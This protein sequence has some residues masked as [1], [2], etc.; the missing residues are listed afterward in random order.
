MSKKN[1]GCLERIERLKSKL[2]EVRPEMDLENA[3]I[4]TES[5]METEGLP[6]V[7]RKAKAFHKQCSEKT[8][9]I[10]E[11][12]LIVGCSGSKK[13]GGILCADTCWSVLDAELDT[14]SNRKYD[15]FYLR[16]EDRA[17]FQEVIKPYWKGRSNYEK[18]LAQVPE[19]TKELTDNGILYINRKAVRGFGET[20]AGYE[21]LL[22]VGISGI[23]K[24]I[25]KSRA[26]LDITVPGDYQK[27]YYLKSQLIAADGIKIL[28]ER[29]AELARKYANETDDLIRKEELNQIASICDSISW[30]PVR[31]F[32]EALQLFYFYQTCIFME[33]N[34]A[35]YNPGRMDQYLWKYYENDLEKG[36]ITVDEAQ[37]LLDCL[38]IKFSEP[39]LFQDEVTAEFAAGY[40]MFQNVCVGGVD[41][42]GR[43]A[44]NDLSYMILQAT[45]DVKL[46]QPSLSVRY[47]VAKNPNSFLKKVVDLMSLGTGFPAFHNDDIGIRMLMNKGIPLKEAFNWNPCGCVETNLEGRTKQYTALADINLGSMVEFALL[48]G[49]M[50][51]NNKVISVRSGDPLEFHTYGKFLEAVKD[52]IRYSVRACVM[53]SH[54]IDEICMDR[55]CPALSLTFKE[56]IESAKDYA[57]GGAKYNVGNGIILIGVADLINSL[58]TVRHIIY[59]EKSTSMS[60]LLKALENNFEGYDILHKM[61]MDAPKYGND[62]PLVDDIAGEIYTFIADEIESYN[63][64]FGKMSPGILPVSGN[65]PFG[66]EVGALPSGRKA[67]TPLADGVSPSG[68]SDMNGPTAVLKSVANIPHDRFTQGTLLNMK[69][70]PSMI[71]NEGG[72]IQMMSLLKSMCTLGV[73]HVQFNVIDQ[74]KLIKAQKDPEKY[75]GLLVRVAGYTAYFTELGKD[76]QDEIIGRTVQTGISV[77]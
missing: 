10:W 69:V 9:N 49:K 74:E 21:W 35:S 68:G 54:V 75:K 30:N 47:S 56:C 36:I 55:T 46:Y 11:D 59:N 71:S 38:W 18:W 64:K 20:T 76:I 50:R 1:K 65:T 22:N 12:E 37:E 17:I 3:R 66:L 77:G 51:K 40:P 70:E 6:H 26:K 24:E 7:L 2:L 8:I 44:V 5:F 15:P 31:S 45:M 16:D 53:G 67:W 33:Q 13:R 28:I 14:I 25:E 48:N 27:D 72:K 39:C 43:D 34:A 41:D 62:D 42:C 63:S 52:Q 29:H 19:E 73:Y 32:R 58:A 61:C 60:E 57:W 4:L 23:V